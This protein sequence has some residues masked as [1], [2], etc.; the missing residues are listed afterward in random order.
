MSFYDSTRVLVFHTVSKHL[1]FTRAAEELELTQPAVTFQIRQLEEHFNTRLFERQ[2]NRISMTDA[3]RLFYLYA[4]RILDLY[5]ET[6]KRLNEVTGLSRGMIRLGATTTPG[7]YLLPGILC[8]YRE[9]YPGVKVRLSLHNTC[10]VVQKVR[11]TT[12]DIGMVEGPVHQSGIEVI[13]CLEDE[14]VVILAPGHPLAA[15][16]NIPLERLLAYPFVSR[17]EGSGTRAVIAAFLEQTGLQLGQ[18]KTVLEVDTA[19]A[20]KCAVEHGIG[21]SLISRLSVRKEELLHALVI[22]RLH[23]GRLTRSIHLVLDA[24][25]IRSKVSDELVHHIQAF[26]QKTSSI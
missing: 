18:L 11:D 8:G 9:V 15:E 2:H 14:L 5:Q 22:R 23:E 21:F 1:S 7:G 3:G 10:T 24:K 4:S 16:E 12:I 25:R 26:C 17:E 13:P 19:E 20:A 6:E